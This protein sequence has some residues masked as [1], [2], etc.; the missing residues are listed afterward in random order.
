MRR[1]EELS[2]EVAILNSNISN[3]KNKIKNLK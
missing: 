3:I 2:N 1:K